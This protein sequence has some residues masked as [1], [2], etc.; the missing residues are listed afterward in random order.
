MN[1]EN[2]EK[3][4]HLK[5]VL[6]KHISHDILTTIDLRPLFH[7]REFSSNLKSNT[8]Y[9]MIKKN[10]EYDVTLMNN[11]VITGFTLPFIGNVHFPHRTVKN[12]IQ[13]PLSNL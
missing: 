6:K 1:R 8:D 7:F 13:V 12:V 4:D 2:V 11:K 5:E 3:H 9:K 10:L